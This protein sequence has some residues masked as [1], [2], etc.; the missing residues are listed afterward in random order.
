MAENASAEIYR[1]TMLGDALCDVLESFVENGK[2]NEAMA[3]TIMK[4]FD[5][6]IHSSCFFPSAWLMHHAYDP[7][8]MHSF[9]SFL[10]ALHTN[11]TKATI[12]ADLKTYKFFDNVST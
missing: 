8:C 11:E 1:Q 5:M 12:N 3:E 2:L 4:Q 7:W 9:Q 6:V 10:E